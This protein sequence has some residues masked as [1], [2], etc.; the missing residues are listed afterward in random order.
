MKDIFTA[1]K[2]LLPVAI[3]LVGAFAV[4][5]ASAQGASSAP[6]TYNPADD[7]AR[8]DEAPAPIIGGFARASRTNDVGGFSAYAQ[9][10]AT[11]DRDVHYFDTSND[12]GSTTGRGNI[13]R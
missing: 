10:P 8:N 3:A 13:G 2:L 6:Q 4:H 9:A 1:R 7:S 12:L 11:I 5:S